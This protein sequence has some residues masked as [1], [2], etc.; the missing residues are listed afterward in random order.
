MA[1]HA[2][3]TPARH[4]LLRAGLSVTAAGA[5]LG[6]GG[7]A[8]QAAPSA[9]TDAS[10]AAEATSGALTGAVGNVAHGAALPLTNLQLD[11]LAK[12]GVD[13][14]DNGVG[15]QIADFKPV[16]TKPLTDPVTQGGALGTLPVTGPVT[17]LLG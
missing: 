17:S 8:A 1:R 16:S 4:A 3:P 12:T 9:G 5:V 14:L 10:Q 7:A 6:L 15:T 2:A 13:P 11:P